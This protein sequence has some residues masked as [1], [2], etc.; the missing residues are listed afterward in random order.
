MVVERAV[1]HKHNVLEHIC[2][3]S[4]RVLE[5]GQE[6]L[7]QVKVGNLSRRPDVVDLANDSLGKDKVEGVGSIAS[8]EVATGRAPISVDDQLVTAVEKARELGDDLLRVLVS[9]G[10]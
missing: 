3:D 7:A 4:H 5:L 2:L 9:G 8:V 6:V 1:A 10:E